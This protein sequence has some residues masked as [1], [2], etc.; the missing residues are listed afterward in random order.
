MCQFQCTYILIYTYIR[1]YVYYIW[2]HIC[3][4]VYVNIYL[5]IYIHICMDTYIYIHTYVHI[6]GH[7]CIHKH[8]HKHTHTHTHTH[9]NTHTHTFHASNLSSKWKLTQ[10][11][12]RH[13][14]N[15]RVESIWKW[16]SR[17]WSLDTIT[18]PEPPYLF[19]NSPIFYFQIF[20][21]ES[22]WKWWSRIWSLD[23]ITSPEPLDL[24]FNLFK[25]SCLKASES[26]GF[27]FGRWTPS[28]APSRHFFFGKLLTV[29][30]TYLWKPKIICDNHKLNK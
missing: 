8:S 15:L 19:F 25:F 2:I 27:A 17:I 13:F 14:R 6:Y 30:V 18:S 11:R 20:V 3:V 4:S 26:G 5:Y 1:I 16:W 28:Q 22:I 9:T 23:T 21:F 29:V 10:W 24:F 7:V 12:S